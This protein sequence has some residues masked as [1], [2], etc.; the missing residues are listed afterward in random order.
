[1]CQ[2]DAA[3]VGGAQ[4]QPTA[5]GAGCRPQARAQRHC[6]RNRVKMMGAAAGLQNHGVDFVY[7]CGDTCCSYDAAAAASGWRTICSTTVK[8]RPARGT[9]RARDLRE[10]LAAQEG[11]RGR[12]HAGGGNAE[13][14]A[15]EAPVRGVHSSPRHLQRV[16]SKQEFG[17]VFAPGQRRGRGRRR[18]RL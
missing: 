14:F 16:N 8:T 7:C 5:G 15:V 1:M 13:H 3:A 2:R 6:T 18:R 4:Q 10:P 11:Q 9:P 17:S 12:M